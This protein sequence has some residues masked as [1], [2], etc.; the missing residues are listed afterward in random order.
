[1]IFILKLIKK[2]VK[3]ALLVA[4][5]VLFF[6][7]LLNKI[8][9]KGIIKRTWTVQRIPSGKSMRYTMSIKDKVLISFQ[10]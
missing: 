6:K 2:A 9:E 4:G 5:A 3:L 10:L 7:L 1:M 8:E